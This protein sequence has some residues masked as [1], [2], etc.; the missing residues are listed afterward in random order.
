MR[1]VPALALAMLVLVAS[2]AGCADSDGEIGSDSIDV[3]TWQVGDWWL[4]TFSTPDY[5]DDTAGSSLRAIVKRVVRP[6]CWP[7]R[8]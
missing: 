5:S 6:T 2:M 8:A 1:S 7:S 4:Y 3:P